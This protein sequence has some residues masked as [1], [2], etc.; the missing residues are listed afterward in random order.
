MNKFDPKFEKLLDAL[1]EGVMF[2]D[3]NGRIIA[4][5]KSLADTFC[6]EKE[7]APGSSLI[8]YIRN[9]ELEDFIKNALDSQRGA[10]QEFELVTPVELVV[11]IRAA[12]YGESEEKRGL[13]VII[14]DMTSTRR[15]EKIRVEFAANVSH[16]LKTPLA[17]IKGYIETLQDGAIDDK[18]N[19]VKFL[20][21]IAEQVERLDRLISDLL[22]LSK[23]ESGKKEITL[24]RF[25]IR[26]LF[27][28]V[29]NIETPAADRKQIA[30]GIDV[31]AG[32]SDVLADK[33]M[34]EIALLNLVDNAVKFTPRGGVTMS[35]ERTGGKTRIS[36][37]DTGIGIPAELLPRIFE[38]F[39]RAEKARSREFGGTGLGLSIVKHVMEVHHGSVLVESEPDK[40]SKF[41]LTFP[42]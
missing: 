14:N 32:F 9:H 40:G 21:I 6:V 24:A 31:P 7:K 5:N 28:S 11:R 10:E 26:E 35:A 15:L 33:N 34:M 16:E 29:K 18:K 37:S 30:L 19:N 41:T 23:I 42:D 22:E 36:V 8:E 1:S 38:R 20:K 3:A 13:L 4:V 27:E 12:L 17:A 39:F 2:L 25:D